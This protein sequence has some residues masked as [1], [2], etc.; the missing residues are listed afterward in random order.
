MDRMSL[1]FVAAASAIAAP[2]EAGTIDRWRAH[3]AESSQRF[4]VPEAWI[5][6]V[7]DA[8]SKGNPRAVSRK[9][10]MGLMQLMPGTWEELRVQFNLGADPFE[11]RANILAG[12]AYLEAMRERFGY[13]GLFA[14]YNAGPARYEEHLR[15]GKPLPEETRAYLAGLESALSSLSRAPVVFAARGA[16]ARASGARKSPRLDA[17]TRLFFPLSTAGNSATDDQIYA[18]VGEL[19]V[20]LSTRKQNE[21]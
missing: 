15:T 7:I 9:G 13:P 1:L 17:K 14:A 19:F 11:P 3:I 6:A 2:A 16:T 5:R 21:N 12:T 18:P 20:P 8:E 10:A 4:D